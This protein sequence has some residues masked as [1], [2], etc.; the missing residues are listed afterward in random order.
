MCNYI[1]SQALNFSSKIQ[2]CKYVETGRCAH[3]HDMSMC[4][5]MLAC[6]S[7]K[8]CENVLMES[9]APESDSCDLS[10][11]T[12]TKE[13]QNTSKYLR[14]IPIKVPRN[15]TKR[16][17]QQPCDIAKDRGQTGG[18]APLDG[19]G[20]GGVGHKFGRKRPCASRSKRARVL[21]NFQ[22]F[23]LLKVAVC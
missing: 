3:L 7:S 17:V 9:A 20:W 2:M 5:A 16:C 12:Y 14:P 23:G 18:V 4:C 21:L 6:F 13:T 19:A 1:A 15:C 11:S 10:P 22:K 8:H